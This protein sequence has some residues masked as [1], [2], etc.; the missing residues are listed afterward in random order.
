MAQCGTRVLAPSGRRVSFLTI[1]TF[2]S[3]VGKAYPDGVFRHSRLFKIVDFCFRSEPFQVGRV[4][5]V[6]AKRDQ[7]A[8]AIQDYAY[9]RS[10]KGINGSHACSLRRDLSHAFPEIAELRGN[11]FNSRYCSLASGP[12]IPSDPIRNYLKAVLPRH[13]TYTTVEMDRLVNF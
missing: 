11:P 4:E 9:V 5:V 1:L 13:L 7:T 10:L 6:E 8:T 3:D 2:H 12:E